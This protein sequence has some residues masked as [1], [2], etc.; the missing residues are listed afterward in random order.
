MSRAQ[1]P[2]AFVLVF[3][4]DNTLWDTDAVFR[5]AQLALLSTL[6]EAGVVPDSHNQLDVLRTLDREL[7]TQLGVAEYDFRLLTVAVS[8]YFA[9]QLTIEVAVR[10][11]L[12][13]PEGDADDL[14]STVDAALTA[15][16]SALANVPPLFPDTQPL[17]AAIRRAISEG[18]PAAVVL[19]SEGNLERIERI[20]DRKGVRRQ[21]FFDE[22]VIA[23]KTI[24][25][26]AHAAQIGRQRLPHGA[27]RDTLTIVIGDSMRRDIL[28][29]NQMGAITVYKPAAF[30][31]I[32]EPQTPDEAPDYTINRLAE[33]PTVLAKIGLSLPRMDAGP[34]STDV[35]VRGKMAS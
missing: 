9:H 3:D 1:V 8:R 23:P 25:G 34:A 10:H 7:I 30:K 12:A 11:A 13:Q 2:T 21:G 26:F 18:T 29:A 27:P 17:L 6:G 33:L 35:P 22:V 19:Y 24:E 20:L 15:F 4:G 14:A 5:L 16:V 28:P 32:E 31:G